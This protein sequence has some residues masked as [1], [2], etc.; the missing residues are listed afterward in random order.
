MFESCRDRQFSSTFLFGGSRFIFPAAGSLRRLR[1]SLTMD[2]VT[3]E[4]GAPA[5]AAAPRSADRWNGA[6]ALAGFILVATA[7]ASNQVLA[8]G[9]ADSVGPF[10]LAFFRW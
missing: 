8:R 5:A 1:D 9:L 2:K 7:Q 6:I 3:S 10:A 4:G